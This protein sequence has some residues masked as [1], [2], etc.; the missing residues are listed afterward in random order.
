VKGN[1][2]CLNVE[3]YETCKYEMRI[4]IVKA[5]VSETGTVSPRCWWTWKAVFIGRPCTLSPFSQC[6]NKEF[7]IQHKNS[8]AHVFWGIFLIFFGGID[9]FSVSFSWLCSV[10]SS[11]SEGSMSDRLVKCMQRSTFP[12]YVYVTV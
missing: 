1:N 6:V 7:S 9:R 12:L 10:F 4:L 5:G 11:I 3:S 8:R 2:R